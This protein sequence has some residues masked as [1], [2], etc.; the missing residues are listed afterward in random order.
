MTTNYTIEQFNESAH[1]FA[2]RLT[3]QKTATIIAL[4]GDLGAGKTTFT[5]AVAD[6]FG[7]QS[8]VV[9]PTFVIQKRYSLEDQPFAQL[10]HIDAYR[11]EGAE[12][13]RVLGWEDIKRDPTNVVLI[14]W[15]EHVEG[16]LGEDVVHIYFTYVDDD[17]RQISYGSKD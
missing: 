12:E 15:P 1:D 11:L 14:E 4:H 16:L 3:P 17:T 13:L 10:I 6:A 7:V 8:E 9:S 5:Q 2:Q